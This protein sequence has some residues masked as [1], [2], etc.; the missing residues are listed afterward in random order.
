MMP[1]LSDDVVVGINGITDNIWFQVL[2]C[3]LVKQGLQ[4]NLMDAL[5]ELSSR[6]NNSLFH[7]EILKFE[8][9]LTHELINLVRY[10]GQAQISDKEFVVETLCR[11][12]LRIMS[13]YLCSSIIQKLDISPD[14]HVLLEDINI[15]TIVIETYSRTNKIDFQEDNLKLHLIALCNFI[16]SGVHLQQPNYNNNYDV[17][18]ANIA[19]RSELQKLSTKVEQE[20]LLRHIYKLKSGGKGA[21]IVHSKILSNKFKQ[22]LLS[23]ILIMELVKN[24]LELQLLSLKE[25]AT[26]VYYERVGNT[27]N[28]DISLIV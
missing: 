12:N 15:G 24:P 17:T 11:D 26:I 19:L 23:E 9:C 13:P 8:N 4:A 27:S 14:E 3:T 1:F 28:I 6:V 16:L 5:F 7:K 2:A 25:E 21:V 20:T 22:I 10:I 18:F